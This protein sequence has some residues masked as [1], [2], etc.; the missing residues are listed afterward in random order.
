MKLKHVVLTGV[1]AAVVA[2]MLLT[3]LVPQTAEAK[4][5][6][7]TYTCCNCQSGCFP[8]T[9][10]RKDALLWCNVADSTFYCVSKRGRTMCA[11][12]NATCAP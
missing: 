5:P 3:A 11:G 10:T 8:Q 9:F 1:L 2:V 7:A 4:G 12:I 6:P